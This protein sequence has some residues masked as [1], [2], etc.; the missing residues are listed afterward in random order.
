MAGLHS[1]LILTF[2]DHGKETTTFAV[3][4]S[5]VAVDGSNFATVMGLMDDVKDAVL[6]VADGCLVSEQRVAR[7]ETFPFVRPAADVQ[8]EASLLVAGI[9]STTG[10]PWH[11]SIGTLDLSLL[12]APAMGR[13]DSWLNFTDAGPGK[14][15]ADA[16]FAY[17]KDGE[18]FTHTVTIEKMIHSSKRS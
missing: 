3:E 13:G 1:K 7:A 2:A 8:R 4:G 10:L 17:V 9:D 16:L 5:A 15:L 18:S 6:A 12:S 11:R 14:N